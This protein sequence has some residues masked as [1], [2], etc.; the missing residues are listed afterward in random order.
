MK[1]N[2]FVKLYE[3]SFP[4]TVLVDCCFTATIKYK[5]PCWFFK[6][7]IHLDIPAI[8]ESEP[9][10]VNCTDVLTFQIISHTF[11]FL[12]SVRDFNLFIYFLKI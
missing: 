5:F 2:L 9:P 8:K 4:E 3:D 1:R 12:S 10:S 7:T 11:A 6:I